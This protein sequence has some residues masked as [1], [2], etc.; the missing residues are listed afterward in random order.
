MAGSR[1]LRSVVNSAKAA[2]YFGWY[3][4]E[5]LVKRPRNVRDGA[6]WLHRFAQ[7]ILRGFGV[8]VTLEGEF[9]ERGVVISDHL[10]Y[11]DII[12]YAALHPV[13]YC[14]KAEVEKMPVL[15][16]MACSAGTVM[17]ERGAG[18]AAERARSGM[19]A[20][21]AEGV[22]VVFFPEGTT[23]TGYSILP[24]RSG[25]LA[26]SLEAEQPIRPAYIRYTLEQ[27][28]G[29]D[30]DLH[31]DVCWG[32]RPMLAHIF[33]FVGLKGVHCWVKIAPEPIR[34]SQPESQIDRKQAAVEARNAVLT[35]A[36]ME[37]G[38]EK[39]PE[40]EDLAVGRR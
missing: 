6:E 32:D 16:F 37:P 30:V 33:K 8:Q 27:D 17:V 26:I 36:G 38:G 25:L 24:F 31:E 29:P 9:P 15:G 1:F 2:A 23:T 22:P 20:A 18:G 10:T 5:L 19:Q 4:L 34:F 40:G 3:G 11:L 13:V 14:S 39:E 21:A 28:N 35:L 12:V 7:S